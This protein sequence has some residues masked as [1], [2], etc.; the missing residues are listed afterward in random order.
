MS[1]QI[2][3]TKSLVQRNPFTGE[4]ESLISR[5]TGG[6]NQI[7][8]EEH[9]PY[10]EMRYLFNNLLL[11]S[12]EEEEKGSKGEEETSIIEIGSPQLRTQWD[13][14]NIFV[15]FSVWVNAKKLK[16]AG[17]IGNS[18]IGEI[19]LG[20]NLFI[21]GQVTPLILAS[22]PLNSLVNKV[23][24]EGKASE[25]IPAKT[26]SVELFTDIACV[27]QPIQANMFIKRSK[28][29]ANS[30]AMK[31]VAVGVF[32]VGPKLIMNVNQTYANKN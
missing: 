4:Y 26:Y 14:Q 16:V 6:P 21:G 7:I 22:I 11:Q 30:V 32:V 19:Q 29:V 13:V 25:F 10:K 27:K 3:L 23:A 2:T 8:V 15:A 1:D 28:A 9:V 18:E 5:F 31:E 24:A 17:E 20:I 12:Q